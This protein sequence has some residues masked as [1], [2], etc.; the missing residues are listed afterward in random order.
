MVEIETKNLKTSNGLNRKINRHVGCLC[1]LWI[2][3]WEVKGIKNTNVAYV[4]PH[5]LKVKGDYLMLEECEEFFINDYNERIRLK[6]LFV[7]TAICKIF[8]KYY[9]QNYCNLAITSVNYLSR[10]G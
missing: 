1:L 10:C 5:I 9:N 3:T 4:K 7:F 2:Y 6:Y 8:R